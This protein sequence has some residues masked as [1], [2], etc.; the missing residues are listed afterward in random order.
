MSHTSITTTPEKQEGIDLCENGDGTW[1]SKAE[2]GQEVSNEEIGEHPKGFRL[3]MVIFALVLSVFLVALD[4][5]YLN[6]FQANKVQADLFR[7]YYC[8]CHTPYHRSIP[9]P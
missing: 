5:V 7:D 6:P 4:L 2:K 9:Q 8:H 1:N 3:A